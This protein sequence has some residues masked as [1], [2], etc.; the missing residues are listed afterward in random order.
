MAKT[1]ATTK[2]PP[3]K[4]VGRKTTE[5]TI[6]VDTPPKKKQCATLTC[7]SVDAM[8]RFTIIPYAQGTK[9]KVDIVLHE[10]GVPPKDAQPQVTLL[11]GGG[12]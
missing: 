12:R 3:A 11:P 6:V 8:R 9:N 7:F 10:G 2:K 4:K 1:A 5:D